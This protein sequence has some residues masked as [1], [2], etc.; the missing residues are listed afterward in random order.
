MSMCLFW[1]E[2]GRDCWRK[3]KCS[4]ASLSPIS[5]TGFLLSVSVSFSLYLC[6][7][8]SLYTVHV[9]PP[10]LNMFSLPPLLSLCL[11]MCPPFPFSLLYIYSGLQ[12]V[13][14]QSQFFPRAPGRDGGREEG[15]TEKR[16]GVIVSH[17]E[18]AVHLFQMGETQICAFKKAK[19]APLVVQC[20]LFGLG[21]FRELRE[22]QDA[23]LKEVSGWSLACY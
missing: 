16:R 14:S 19:W 17:V 23:N 12:T 20:T 1:E 8:L 13:C 3:L 7:S 11:L 6:I 21:S 15:R 2:R 5:W 22:I 18:H 10:T 4:L 9:C